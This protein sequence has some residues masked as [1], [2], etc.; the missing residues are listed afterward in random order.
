VLLLQT[1]EMVTAVVIT[2]WCKSTVWLQIT[3]VQRIE[4]I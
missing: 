1:D 2:L 3:L 4:S